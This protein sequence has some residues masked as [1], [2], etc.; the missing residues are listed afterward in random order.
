MNKL[1]LFVL[2][3]LIISATSA[4][5]D[6][7]MV[8]Y[9][10]SMSR[11]SPQ[12]SISKDNV[13]QLQV[14][15]ILNVNSSVENAPLIVGNTGYCQNN[16]YMQVIAFDMNT[17]LTKW[18]YNPNFTTVSLERGGTAHGMAYENG[19]IYAPTGGVGTI[20]AL[21]AENGSVIWESPSIMPIG[22]AFQE[23]A[24][25]LIWKDMI[26]AGSSG[27]DTPPWGIPIRGTV[28]GLDK[29]T[30]KMVW[31]TKTAIG[32]W[33]EANNTSMNGGATVWSGGAIDA[34]KGIAYLPCGNAAPDMTAVTRPEPNLYA[35][36]VLAINLTDGKILWNT[37][38][39]AQG[40]VFNATVPDLHDY[41]PSF[42]T[43][44]ATVDLGKGPQNIVIAHD[45]RGD[46]AAL[47]AATG[48]PI[49]SKTLGV[50]YRDWAK[51]APAPNG[52]GVVWPGTQNGVESY[53]AV[54]NDTAYAAVSNT[55]VIFYLDS[56]VEG[57][58]APAFD[59]MPNGIGNGSIY[60]LDLKT[61]NIKWEYKSD[62]PTWG[63]PLVT[64]GLVFA[65]RITA[66]GKPYAYSPFAQAVETPQIP[67]GIMMA[68]DSDTG[69]VLWE[70][71][72]GAPVGIGGASIGN[73]MLLVPTGSPAEVRSN[74]GGYI[75]AFGL[76]GK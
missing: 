76:P 69:K 12:T 29:K 57:R 1:A 66:T 39:A 70:F 40:N 73:G 24:P 48:K 75:V 2:A 43:S 18:K 31:Q 44:L 58:V 9:D 47:D 68:L 71:N 49:W 60:A 16:K 50:I 51:P 45:K 35:N 14:K 52:S 38:M 37:P 6:W 34:E 55:G 27:G 62:F 54:D 59:S 10:G 32:A 3:I 74:P 64:N 36:Q 63:S 4:A 53:T 17:G 20:V 19:T 61:G 8:N 11:H 41:D 30:G 46:I 5:Q 7:P 21:N 67:S 15:W 28:T 65:D 25:P 23:P 33:V 42:G 72:V 13:G 56:G 26:I 22:G